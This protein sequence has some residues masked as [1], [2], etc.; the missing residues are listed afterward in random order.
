MLL[1]AVDERLRLTKA[2]AHPVLEREVLSVP[3]TPVNPCTV[4]VTPGRASRAAL[5]RG[6][7]PPTR[8]SGPCQFRDGSWHAPCLVLDRRPLRSADQERDLEA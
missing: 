4:V 6:R 7:A 3:K 2:V 5:P 1:K 8:P